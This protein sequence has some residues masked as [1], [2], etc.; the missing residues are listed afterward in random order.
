M[1]AVATGG[2]CG[3]V[4]EILKI[5]LNLY[6]GNESQLRKVLRYARIVVVNW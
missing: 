6:N 3:C 5:D 1:D 2:G 4:A